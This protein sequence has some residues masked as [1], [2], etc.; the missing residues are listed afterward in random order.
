MRIARR[1]NKKPVDAAHCCVY[2]IICPL[3]YK[4][5]YI[6]YTS[7][8]KSRISYHINTNWEKNKK[9]AYIQMLIKS[10]VSPHFKI[11]S[12]FTSRIAAK[13][14]ELELIELFH[15]ILNTK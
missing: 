5:V 6:G 10:G 12:E 4:I 9:C 8:F 13:K 3:T 7:N 14:Y 2:V 15:P 1:R 11:M